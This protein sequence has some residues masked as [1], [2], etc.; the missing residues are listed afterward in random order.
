MSQIVIFEATP[1][2]QAMKFIITDRQ[3]ASESAQF[4]NAQDSLRSPLARKL[5]GFPWAAGVF[6]GTNFVT[7]TKQEWVDWQVL[8]EPLAN[9]IEEHVIRGE[10]VLLPL[11]TEEMATQMASSPRQSNAIASDDS[12]IVQQIKMILEREI[13][14]AVAMDGGDISFYKY[15]DGRVYLEMHGSCSGCPSS[16]L[17]L[18]QGIETRLRSAIPEIQEVLSIN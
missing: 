9:L 2:P 6:V 3:I 11:T 10:T 16:T 12:P 17:T 5:F 7:V 15:E 8:A 13:R 14:P 4:S 18:K 1:N